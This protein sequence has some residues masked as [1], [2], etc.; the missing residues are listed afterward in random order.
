[1]NQRV[2]MV[3]TAVWGL[4]VFKDVDFEW[5]FAALPKGTP[6]F[7]DVVFT[8]PWAMSSV[9]EHPDEAWKFI[10]FLVS[11]DAQRAYMQATNAPPVRQSLMPEWSTLFSA[12]MSP[13]QVQQVYDGA[14]SHG[15]ESPNHLLVDYNEI[16]TV[17]QDG[18]SPLWEDCGTS[19]TDTL[20]STDA[21][22]EQ[23]LAWIIEMN[24]VP[25]IT[26]DASTG[27]V[28]TTTNGAARLDFGTGTV[29]GTTVVSATSEEAILEA[30]GLAS[31]DRV[32]NV[33]ATASDTGKVL[34]KANTSYTMSVSY[35]EGALDLLTL[36]AVSEVSQVPEDSLA[37]YWWN[38]DL[39]EW[40]RE[41]SSQVDTVANVVCATPNR[42]GLFAVFGKSQVYLPLVVR[43]D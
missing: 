23:T 20:V 28:V 29:S 33:V 24:T 42:F 10:K 7:R 21:Q 35:D 12:T 1:M 14:F 19:V 31:V 27:G 9:T 39:E 5:G 26:L 8:D 38:S 13:A 30:P 3:P 40:E 37:L 16:N 18:L 15:A 2:A 36:R 11:Q 34:T 32:V 4:W 25:T 22:L 41:A 17:L 6:G 43:D